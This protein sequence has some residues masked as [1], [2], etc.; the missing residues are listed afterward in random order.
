M[1]LIELS[2][3]EISYIK[4][5]I[6]KSDIRY[7]Y[8]GGLMIDHKTNES[9][10]PD[11]SRKPLTEAQIKIKEKTEEKQLKKSNGFSLEKAKNI[12]KILG[13]SFDKFTPE[14][15]LEGMN[16]ELEHGKVDKE[17]NVTDDN[18]LIT[19]KIA[20]AH[21]NEDSRYY[22]KLRTIEKNIVVPDSTVRGI[23]NEKIIDTKSVPTYQNP[24]AVQNT[25]IAPINTVGTPLNESS[26]RKE[27]LEKII[28]KAQK[29]GYVWKGY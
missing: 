21:L 24:T 13:I 27:L 4:N 1:V 7:S 19:G 29:C 18:A 6:L 9:V 14:I 26:V 12:G 11:G 8:R 3:D 17:T 5:L 2:N 20:L 15:F 16:V 10:D 23:P 22:E 28:Q 25:H